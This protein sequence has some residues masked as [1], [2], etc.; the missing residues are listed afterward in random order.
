MPVKITTNQPNTI[1]KLIKKTSNIL[2]TKTQN[3][4]EKSTNNPSTN[5][6]KMDSKINQK[7]IPEAS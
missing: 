4:D 3:I 7:S 1:E 2:K 6:P 5:P